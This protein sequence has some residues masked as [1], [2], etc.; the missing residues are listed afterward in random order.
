VTHHHFAN[1][2]VVKSRRAI[3]ALPFWLDKRVYNHCITG[4]TRNGIHTIGLQFVQGTREPQPRGIILLVDSQ[5]RPD[6]LALAL[7]G[8]VHS[9]AA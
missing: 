2:F 5:Y 9:E 4:F 8:R 3:D 1:A 7:A 6:C